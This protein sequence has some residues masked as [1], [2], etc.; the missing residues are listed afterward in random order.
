MNAKNSNKDIGLGWLANAPWKKIDGVHLA[1]D[2]Q[3]DGSFSCV[4]ANC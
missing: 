2:I 1:S 4:R 3:G